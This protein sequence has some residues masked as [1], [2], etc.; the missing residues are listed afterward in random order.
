M[1]LVMN[2]QF[3]MCVRDSLSVKNETKVEKLSSA[4]MTLVTDQDAVGSFVLST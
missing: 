4:A 1:E 3:M 2:F